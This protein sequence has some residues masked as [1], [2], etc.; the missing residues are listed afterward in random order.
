MDYEKLMEKARETNSAR[1]AIDT[2]FGHK[3][4][5]D[6]YP[7]V[8]FLTALEALRAGIVTDDWNAIAEGLALLEDHIMD[9]GSIQWK[10]D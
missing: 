6:V 8:V 10:R 3:N 2:E 9:N 7:Q 4:M 5:N 1:D